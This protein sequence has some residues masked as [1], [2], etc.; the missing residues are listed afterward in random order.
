MSKAHLERKVRLLRW[1][2][3]DRDFQPAQVDSRFKVLTKR[4]ITSYC[5]IT[6]D[7]GLDSFQQLQLNYD[8]E[9]QDFFRYLQLRHCLDKNITFLKKGDA[10]LIDIVIDAYKGKIHNKVVTRIYSW[11]QLHKTCQYHMSKVLGRKKQ[12]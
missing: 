4:R 1:V 7:S 12:I 3:H 5:V 10:D 9:K 8:L 6:S 11:L 2:E